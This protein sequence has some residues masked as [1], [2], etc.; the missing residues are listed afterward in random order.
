[1][2]GNVKVRSSELIG[3][4]NISQLFHN[5]DVNKFVMQLCKLVKQ[6]VNIIVMLMVNCTDSQLTCRLFAV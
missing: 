4:Q 6:L 1:M 3:K 5:P 2:Q